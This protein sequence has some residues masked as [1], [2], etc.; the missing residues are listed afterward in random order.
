MPTPQYILRIREK[1]GHDLM[2]LPGVSGVVLND[3]GHVL[4]VRSAH[5]EE[6]T[7]IGG[8][9]EPGEEPAD[10]LAREI[11]EETGITAVPDLLVSV[12]ALDAVQY[13]NGDRAAYVTTTFRCRAGPEKPRVADE[14]STEVR[15]FA[16]DAL[17]NLPAQQRR[18]IELALRGGPQAAFMFKASPPPERV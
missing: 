12:D 10:T 6:W 1:I 4:L 15:Y 9:M 17:P 16:P 7:I 14:E 11:G 8:V 5:S 18:R 13:P 3:A 2:L